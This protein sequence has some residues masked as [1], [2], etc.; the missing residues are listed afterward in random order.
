MPSRGQVSVY[1]LAIDQQAFASPIRWTL[2]GQQHQ[3]WRLWNAGAVGVREQ[4]PSAESSESGEIAAAGSA[5]CV[6]LITGRLR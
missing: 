6:G 1:H 4:L 2:T 5:V 3:A